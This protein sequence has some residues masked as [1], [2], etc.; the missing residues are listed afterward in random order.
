MSYLLNFRCTQRVNFSLSSRSSVCS[1]QFS[2]V[3]ASSSRDF[4]GN[5]RWSLS[6]SHGSAVARARELFFARLPLDGVLTITPFIR[7]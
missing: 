7:N 6:T 4:T 1:L 3:C 2:K 5:S